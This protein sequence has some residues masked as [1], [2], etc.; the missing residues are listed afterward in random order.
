MTA[1]RPRRRVLLIGLFVALIGAW[2]LSLSIGAM[3]IPVGDLM[4]SIWARL[5][6]GTPEHAQYEAVLWQLRMPRTLLGILVGATLSVGGALMQG[7]F[8]NPL[9]DPGLIGVSSGAAAGAV[10]IVV[11]GA[12]VLPDLPILQDMRA[13]PFAAFLGAVVVTLLV[14][15]LATNSGYTAVAT[16]LL[17]GVAINAIVQGLIGLSTFLATDAQLRT[18]SFW[19][20]G[21][22]G[23][24]NWN[25]VAAAA[26]FCLGLILVA[27]F[28]GGV[29]NAMALGEAEAGHLG[30]SVEKV[31]VALVILTAA[32]VA[33][34]VA[35]TGI[36]AFVGLVVPHIVRFWLGPDHRWLLPGSAMLG[37]MILM[38]ADTVSRVVVA[39]A[40]LPLGVVTAALGG[41]FFLFMLLRQRSKALWG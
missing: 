34:S 4:G 32:G 33:G 5:T 23:G 17:A 11:L 36:I 2:L 37:G 8:R 21:S 10:L 3:R 13:L 26:P 6:G 22:L 40:E 14:Q 1:S 18:V 41:P 35:F 31:K 12:A 29:L 30:F 20:L 24:A 38:L 15:R 16:L 9:A 27:P 28:F 7:L 25:I 19:L 39:P